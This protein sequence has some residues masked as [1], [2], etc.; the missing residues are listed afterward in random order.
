MFGTP[1]RVVQLKMF[2]I[3]P[4]PTGQNREYERSYSNFT[5]TTIGGMGYSR[6]LRFT[7]AGQT[8]VDCMLLNVRS[9]G[10]KVRAF[11]E[12]VL[13]AFVT[14]PHRKQDLFVKSLAR[15][16]LSQ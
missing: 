7:D 16:K 8:E 2:A 9:F 11:I 12:N 4:Y 5:D 3:A 10:H 13:N 15:T 6:R 14:A 1:L